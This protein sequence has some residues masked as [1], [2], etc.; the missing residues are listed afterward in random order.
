MNDFLNSYFE[1]FSSNLFQYIYWFKHIIY[2]IN[3]I[4]YALFQVYF[5]FF[6]FVVV[7][8][9]PLLQNL[10]RYVVTLGVIL[11]V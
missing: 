2:V 8:Y 3:L 1:R 10:L 7:Y 6:F 11:Y 5:S 9:S 4:F